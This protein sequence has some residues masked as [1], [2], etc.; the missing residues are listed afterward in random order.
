VGVK[1]LTA[2]QRDDKRLVAQ[3]NKLYEITL[4]RERITLTYPGT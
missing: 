2:L 1:N 4:L 3:T